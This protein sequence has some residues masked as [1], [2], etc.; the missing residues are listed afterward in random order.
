MF[1]D[2]D[3]KSMAINDSFYKINSIFMIAKNVLSIFYFE[4][5]SLKYYNFF[6]EHFLKLKIKYF[7]YIEN[8]YF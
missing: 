4:L 6:Y 7:H 5:Q 2:Y 8:V 1:K 3:I